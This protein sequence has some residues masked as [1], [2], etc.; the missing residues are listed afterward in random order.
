M[1]PPYSVP[2]SPRTPKP[3][4]TRANKTE[5]SRI[6]KPSKPDKPRK[7]DTLRKS[8]DHITFP[9]LYL[10]K[11]IGPKAAAAQFSQDFDG[12]Y[13]NSLKVAQ[14]EN[15]SWFSGSASGSDSDSA[16]ESGSDSSKK[17]KMPSDIAIVEYTEF[18]KLFSSLSPASSSS[19]SSES[20]DK[21]MSPRSM[22]QKSMSPYMGGRN[23][24]K[25]KTKKNTR[26][27]KNTP[28]RRSGKKYTQHKKRTLKHYRK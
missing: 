18:M 5:L 4:A 9:E 10:I 20:E 3:R 27:N 13:K 22:S 11:E 12:A 26:K 21:S 19:S 16:S 23:R 1:E 14:S 24:K 6:S 28:R 8:S 17:F 2:V 15:P 7:S 25:N